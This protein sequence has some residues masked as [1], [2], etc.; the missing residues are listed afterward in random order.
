MDQNSWLLVFL[1]IVVLYVS[2]NRRE[3]MFHA[4]SKSN[5]KHKLTGKI[6]ASPSPSPS[7][8]HHQLKKSGHA[9]TS[10]TQCKSH[11]CQNALGEKCKNTSSF[12]SGWDVSKSG[13]FCY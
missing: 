12:L 13:C 3:Q 4:Y 7:P 2:Q 11:I 5:P 8:P 1:L 6:N 9:C 10:N